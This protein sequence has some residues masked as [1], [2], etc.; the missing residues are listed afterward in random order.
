MLHLRNP[1]VVRII[2]DSA[3]HYRCTS[4]NDHIHQGPDLTNKLLG[5][6]LK[7]RQEPIALTADI[8]G[9][10]YQVRVT[11]QERDL[12]W[13][14]WWE[15]GDPDKSPQHYR[16]T[17]HFLGDDWSP[18]AATFALQVVAEE[19]RGRISNGALETI[20]K[21]FHV[22]DCMK[23][24]STVD[25]AIGLAADLRESLATGGFRV[26]KWLRIFRM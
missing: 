1:D 13:F 23:S 10:F 15:D 7:F 12:L 14:L 26:T 22:D 9:M 11:P 18:S 19:Y 20:G 21:N 2:F 16:K 4:L 17:T 6:L 5:I 3:A 25:T 8:E 24:V